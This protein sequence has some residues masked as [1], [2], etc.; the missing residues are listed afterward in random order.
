MTPER[1][2]RAELA[3]LLAA[4]WL[5][6]ALVDGLFASALSRFGYGSTVTRLWQG[7]AATV[8]GPDAFGGG[9]ATMALGLVM[10]V[11][12]ALAWSALFVAAIVAWPALRRMVVGI[13]GALAVAAVYGPLVW[14][15]MSFAV[16]PA[17]TGRPPQVGM[18]WWIQLAGHIGFVALPMVLVV[19]HYLRAELQATDVHDARSAA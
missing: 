13:G 9:L 3:P 11:G 8:V 4:A 14:I 2:S 1:P 18:R 7:V 16:I 10:H 17:L 19:R 15:V 12:V 6:T 5:A